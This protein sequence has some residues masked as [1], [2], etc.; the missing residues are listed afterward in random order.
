MPNAAAPGEG[1]AKTYRTIRRE[2]EAYGHGLGEKHEIVALNKCDAIPPGELAKKR[3][4]LEKASGE[5]VFLLSGVSGKG[6][7]DVLRAMAREIGER[8]IERAE[9]AQMRRP[10]VVRAPASRAE[11]QSVNF[12]APVVPQSRI[13][14][15]EYIEQAATRGTPV[16]KKSKP[17]KGKIVTTANVKGPD[18]KAKLT[19][20]K[21]KGKVKTARKTVKTAG[22]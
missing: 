17:V 19:K 6:V 13:A 1:I 15:A 14:E 2:L 8:R 12:H 9:R 7:P 18:K 16:V 5:K 22:R 11:R 20:A 10:A 3:A 21:L 4:A